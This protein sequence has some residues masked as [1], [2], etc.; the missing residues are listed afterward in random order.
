MAVD[1]LVMRHAKSDWGDPMLP[2]E[3]RPLAPRGNR[4][5][6]RMAEWL[7]EKELAPDRVLSSSAVRTRETV[8]HLIYG[9]DLDPSIVEF[10]DDLYL[11][12]AWDWIDALRNES[13]ARLLICGHNPGFDDLVDWLCAEPP[14]RTLDGKLMTTAA[15]AH[16][17]FDDAWPAIGPTSGRLHSLVRPREL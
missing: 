16:I 10:R 6:A 17:R 1:L 12:G 2:D 9:L 13:V 8:A 11:A 15:I 3:Q 4:A 7:Q 5:A 14:A